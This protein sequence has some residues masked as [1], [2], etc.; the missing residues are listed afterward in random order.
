VRRMLA[1]CA[2]AV[3]IFA[4][5]ALAQDG[6]GPAT[7]LVH[8]W[9]Y[10]SS[11]SPGPSLTS[12]MPLGPI[13]VAEALPPRAV[14][15]SPT[16]DAPNSMPSPHLVL[17]T[18]S[19]TPNRA[20]EAGLFAEA[21]G[22]A[23]VA[24]STNLARPRV[25]TGEAGFLGDGGPAL[26]SELSLITDSLIERSGIAVASDG[27]VFIADTKN[28]T[29]RA[30]SGILSSTEPNI[31]RSVAGKWGPRQNVTLVEPMGIAVD[32]AG[33]LYIADHGA[34]A[35]DVLSATTGQLEILAHVVSPANIAVTQDGAKVFVASPETGGVFAITTATRA[36]AVV[37]GFAPTAAAASD[38]S[39][40]LTSGPCANV[41]AA[42]AAAASRA[43]TA[44]VAPST[45]AAPTTSAAAQ[46]ICPSGLAADGHAN[47]FVADANAGK[48][49]R[50]DATTNKMTT[51]VAGM[52]TPGDIQFDHE[53]DLFVAEQGRMRI[54]AF[55]A[56]GIPAS[57]LTITVPALFPVPCPQVSNPF[58]FCNEP[59]GGVSQQAIF[60]V[61]NTSASTITGL[62][63][64]PAFVP[65][66]TNPL[67][68][69]T[70]FTTENTSCTA[71][72]APNATCTISVA[73]TPLT[74][75][76]ITG[77]L[78]VTDIQG[79]ST[80]VNLAGTG[81]TF[82]LQLASGQPL[83]VT[84]FQG[85]TATFMAQ[86][87]PDN[88]YGANGEQ[89]SFS[90][91]ANLPQFSTCSF[92]PCPISITPGTAASF[93]IVIVTSS[94]VQSAPNVPNPCDT[95]ASSAVRG[96]RVGTMIF[97]IAP[98]APPAD[99]ARFPALALLAIFGA[100]A[101]LL[102]VIYARVQSP[103]RRVSAIF[104]VATFAALIFAGCGG[105]KGVVPSP[106]TPVGVTSMTILG[107]ALDANGNSLNASRPLPIILGVLKGN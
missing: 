47:L 24:Y 33:N 25:G 80:T 61:T 31:I 82:S 83:Q 89:V 30:I 65:P 8:D 34:G 88:V 76:A 42:T 99:G 36:I 50:V 73:F 81:D 72:L 19:D 53:G 105:S 14:G 20:M 94:L 3:T 71:T 2:V 103:S 9:N 41:A 93:N 58:T 52:I 7:V 21:M 90:C 86:V 54:L 64:T 48:I 10:P 98:P 5:F 106:A 39:A 43:A 67:P 51:P 26:A 23:I 11:Y 101:L 55:G 79:D 4:A 44:T 78:S 97:R 75:G 85:Q 63:I 6:R 68:P 107:N 22:V 104:A 13:T 49:L 62:T 84:I 27:T 57:N 18:R 17:Y 28:G 46:Q 96:P 59:Q 100:I 102:G 37:P 66:G 91:P 60:T 70:N 87:V 35:V 56:L 74:T 92:N 45:S 32:A 40:T 69:P 16:A 38:N 95:P 12:G 1:F 15:V 29:I 77:S